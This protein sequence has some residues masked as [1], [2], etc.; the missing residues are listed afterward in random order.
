MGAWAG[1]VAVAI[2]VCGAGVHCM[3]A[4]LVRRLAAAALPMAS[5]VPALPQGVV[6]GKD[7]RVAM[8]VL[9]RW[10]DEIGEPVQGTRKA[11]GPRRRSR[12]AWADPLAALVPR[13]RVAN[14]AD[15]DILNGR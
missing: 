3:A 11:R 13:Q 9:A 4:A 14:A 7:F 6:R 2:G 1:G 5:V 8:P 15:P 10:R 12:S